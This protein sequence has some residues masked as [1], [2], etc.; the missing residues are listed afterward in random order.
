M[1]T[2]IY[3]LEGY[4]YLKEAEVDLL[5]D[6]INSFNGMPVCL[7][8]LVIDFYVIYGLDHIKAVWKEPNLRVRAYKSEM[9]PAYPCGAPPRLLHV[10]S[11]LT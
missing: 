2:I 9:T 5:D 1:T 7:R 6:Y 3:V 10:C 8:L 11:H 4:C